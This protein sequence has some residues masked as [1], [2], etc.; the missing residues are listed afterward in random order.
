MS[1]I[2]HFYN[3]YQEAMHVAANRNEIGMYNSKKHPFVFYNGYVLEGGRWLYDRINLN[4]KEGYHPFFGTDFHKTCIGYFDKVHKKVAVKANHW[5]TVTI[6]NSNPWKKD[7]ISDNVYELQE[8]PVEH[9]FE[10]G[11]KGI[12]GNEIA[13]VLITSWMDCNIEEYKVIKTQ[14][15]ICRVYSFYTN[16]VLEIKEALRKVKRE[17]PNLAVNDSKKIFGKDTV[18]LFLTRDG[19]YSV[20]IPSISD[21]L[22]NN[23]FTKEE[24]KHIEMCKFYTEYCYQEGFSWKE[25][26]DNWG[27]AK[28][29]SIV[30]QI[31]AKRKRIKE[32]RRKCVEDT[33]KNREAALKKA[34][35]GL[36]LDSWRE[37][38]SIDDRPSF[39]Y[40]AYQLNKDNLRVTFNR[41]EYL[42]ARFNNVE[43]KLNDTK[44]RV[45]T[46]K[47]AVVSLEDAIKLFN[48]LYR[49]YMI[50]D[51]YKFTDFTKK[52]I[53]LDW[54]TLR[55]INYLEKHTDDGQK[56]GYSDWKI[57]I[58]C[59]AIWMEEVKEFCRYYHLEDKVLFD[60][61]PLNVEK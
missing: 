14:S 54:Y 3:N 60:C 19:Y 37:N 30:E 6:F 12:L 34:Q 16:R 31:I 53:K 13:K 21:I 11:N 4:I 45:I 35:S 42:T 52:N 58:G 61:E 39:T 18:P 57:Q 49:F 36:S 29:D 33:A 23:V 44:L 46:S 41:R 10:K 59:H 17:Y 28:L 47:G 25:V 40:N 27:T 51:D 22:N 9:I 7:N 48:W 50:K 2:K 43:L 1:Q 8:I 56:L 55:H 15:K 38:S 5:Y 24:L 20:K 32:L 26:K